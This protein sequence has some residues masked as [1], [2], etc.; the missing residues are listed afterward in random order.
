MKISFLATAFVIFLAFAGWSTARA[1]VPTL[2]G[3]HKVLQQAAGD[4]GDTAPPAAQQQELISK[5]IKMTQEYP[6]L[7]PKRKRPV[8]DLLDAALAAAQ[9]GDPTQARS[10]ILEAD[11]RVKELA[12]RADE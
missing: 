2:D 12:E 7:K 8:L 4:S 1:D 5:A 3:V 11:D 10:K 6:G 9:G